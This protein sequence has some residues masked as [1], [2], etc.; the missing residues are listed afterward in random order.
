MDW[1]KEQLVRIRINLANRTLTAGFVAIATT[2][3]VGLLWCQEPKSIQPVRVAVV[4]GGHQYETSFDSLFEGSQDISGTVLPRDIAFARNLR[5]R[6]D[7]LVFYDLTDKIQEREQ[8][9]FQDFVDSGKGVLVMHHAIA[10]YW[11]SWPWYQ[12]LTGA[13]YFL[14]PEG[15]TPASKPALGQQVLA[16]PVGKHPITAG[17]EAFQLEDETYK[18]WTISPGAKVLL[19]TDNPNSERPLA[20]ISPYQKSRVVVILLGHDRKAHLHPAFRA[21]VRNAMLWLAG[22]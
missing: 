17:L 18:G 14:K 20:W 5:T 13:R 19:E 4:T 10:S 7:V 12:E 6:F 8:K 9:N 15:N 21:L 16:K 2:A 22:R 11:N 1:G 3:S